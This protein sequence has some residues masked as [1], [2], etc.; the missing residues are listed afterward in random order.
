[1]KFLPPAAALQ[2]TQKSSQAVDNAAAFVE[3]C[4]AEVVLSGQHNR[5]TF[6]GVI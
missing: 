5:L 1:M 6:H 2:L 4:F 3:V